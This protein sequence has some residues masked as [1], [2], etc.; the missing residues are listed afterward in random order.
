VQEEAMIASLK[1]AFRVAAAAAALLTLS[2]AQ[3]IVY[4]GAWDPLFGAPF[5][6]PP[7]LGWRGTVKVDVPLG[8]VGGD[9][10]FLPTNACGVPTVLEA[11][12]KLYKD[13]N[14]TLNLETLDFEET[15]MRVLG[16]D[17]T[18]SE[19][20]WIWTAPS[21]W[22]PSSLVGGFFSLAFLTP[23]VSAIL[24]NVIPE[25]RTPSPYGGPV[26]LWSSVDI[27]AIPIDSLTDLGR[28]ILAISRVEV[29]DVAENPPE[30]LNGGRLFGAGEVEEIPE[31]GSLALV[32]LALFA[33]G[34]VTRSR[35]RQ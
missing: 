22:V 8:C 4:S 17:Y 20:E 25:L 30:F 5:G 2:P 32:A 31:P 24:D 18:G 21:N 9:R 33:T 35:R 6:S 19:L 11:E 28:L 15:S 3:A 12:V 23:Q 34:W 29:S 7:A 10:L 27:G 13:N 14:P 1:R 16:L 26:L